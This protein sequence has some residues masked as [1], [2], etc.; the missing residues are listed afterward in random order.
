MPW[1]VEWGARMIR[2]VYELPDDLAERL[3]RRQAKAGHQSEAALVRSLLE[4]A[5][6]LAETGLELS[7]RLHIAIES[8]EDSTDAARRL[9]IGHPQFASVEHEAGRPTFWKDRAGTVYEIPK[10][11]RERGC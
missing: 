6:N 7:K 3:D 11:A 1:P 9:L 2:R 8:G 5:L 10:S 4:I